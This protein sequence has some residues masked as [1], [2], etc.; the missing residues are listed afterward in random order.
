MKEVYEGRMLQ[1]QMLLDGIRADFNAPQNLAKAYRDSASYTHKVDVFLQQKHQLYGF[2]LNCADLVRHEPCS[3]ISDNG[4]F[5]EE[6]SP[7]KRKLNYDVNFG[8]FG[9][10]DGQFSE[11]AGIC[12][13]SDGLNAVTDTKNQRV[14][15]LDE[16]G[17]LKLSIGV[18]GR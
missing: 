4:S 14:Q 3:P 2:C 13:T 7:R 11:H 6:F 16:L 1:G 15:V 9:V 10:E 12:V 8:S 5:F 17:C 18:G